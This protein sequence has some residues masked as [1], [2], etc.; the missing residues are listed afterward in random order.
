MC[1]CMCVGVCVCLSALLYMLV[2]GVYSHTVECMES[3]V[4][5]GYLMDV[6]GK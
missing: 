2:A 1:A 3:P 4:S 5:I 6:K